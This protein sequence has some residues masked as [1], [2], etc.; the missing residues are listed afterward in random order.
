M[1]TS[2]RYQQ[3]ADS[4]AQADRFKEAARELGCDEDES[5]FDEKLRRVARHQPR[6]CPECGHMFQGNGWD[7]IDAHWRAKHER[8]M[9]YEEAWPLVKAGT[10]K[11]AK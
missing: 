4:K 9:P 7:G 11:P 10:Y 6:V 5:A 3:P 2:K 1:A 8:T